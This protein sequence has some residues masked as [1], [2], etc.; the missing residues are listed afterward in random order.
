[1]L[2][3]IGTVTDG[4]ADVAGNA[5]IVLIA[6]PSRA[7]RLK[8]RFRG[9]D[10][11]FAVLGSAAVGANELIAIASNGLA[12]AVDPTPSFSSSIATALV[13]DTAA[14]NLVNSGNP[15]AGTAQS[16]FH[17]DCVALK[18]RLIVSW[19]L[20]TAGALAWVEDVIW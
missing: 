5:P 7:R 17:V 18:L 10:T 20:R 3:D 8:L 11:G 12:S 15:T 2:E 9:V 1:M 19:G 4:V 6:A 16:M 13:M 14:G